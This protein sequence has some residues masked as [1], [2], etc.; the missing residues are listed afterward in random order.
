MRVR[1]ILCCVGFAIAGGAAGC[2]GMHSPQDIYTF[3]PVLGPT[4]D[5]NQLPVAKPQVIVPTVEPA[6]ETGQAD[7]PSYRQLTEAMCLILADR[8][9]PARLLIREMEEEA[10][11]QS[12][13]HPH[14]KTDTSRTQA[15]GYAADEVRNRSLGQAL[16]QYYQLAGAEAGVQLIQAADKDIQEMITKARSS[17]KLGMRDWADLDTLES[18]WTQTRV[19][20]IDLQT[21]IVELNTSLKVLLGLPSEPSIHLWPDTPLKV[22]NQTVNEEEAVQTG[23][24]YRPDLLLL[25]Y[26]LGLP[27]DDGK[28]TSR[29]ILAGVHPLLSGPE[30]VLP[31]GLQIM[32][33]II[34]PRTWRAGNDST[35]MTT[36][37]QIQDLLT[38]RTRQAEAEIR[39]AVAKV[40]AT[41]R[42]ARLFN[43]DVERLK[44]RLEDLNREREA[45]RAVILEQARARA[46]LRTAEGK[47][48]ETVVAHHVAQVKLRQAQGLL[49][50]ELSGQPCCQ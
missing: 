13:R 47:L 3:Q 49:I 46:D 8:N 18:Q 35:S 25:R 19:E 32:V 34:S 45:G 26:L 44:K 39:V 10:G 2:A 12:R 41:A 23:L 11:K 27:D 28:S 14:H 40:N 31:K 33:K 5:L 21:S 48:L 20:A 1:S 16:E 22:T 17:T 6:T 36:T 29:Q 50:R 43:T 24:A 15:L 42:Q 37:L 4:E 38:E 30:Q 9:S 7:N